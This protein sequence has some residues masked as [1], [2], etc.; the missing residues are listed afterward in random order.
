[1]IGLVTSRIAC[2]R[3]VRPGASPRAML[4]ST[5]STTTIASSTTM[6]IASTRPNSDSAF[7]EKPKRCID[8]ERADE[9]HG[10]GRE[11]NDRRAPGLQEQHDDEHDEQQRLERACRTTASIDCAHEHRRVVDDVVVDALREILRE[12]APSWRAPCSRSRSRCC[13][14]AGRWGSRRPARCRAASAARRCSR[15]ARRARRRC[16]RVIWPCSPDLDD[17]VLELFLGDE[18]ALR[19]D[20]GAGTAPRSA[21]AARRAGRPRPAR[22]A[23]GSRARRRSP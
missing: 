4:R 14:G 23:R 7:S 8:G 12:L 13:P 10:H 20:R 15:R 19:V 2:L 21:P 18:A 22:S 5:F 11:R 16:R 1:M 3:G 6:P 9:R 17:D